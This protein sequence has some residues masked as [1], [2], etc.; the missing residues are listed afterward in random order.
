M[1]CLLDDDN[2]CCSSYDDV[3]DPVHPNVFNDVISESYNDIGDADDLM[4]EYEDMDNYDDIGDQNYEPLQW[5]GDDSLDNKGLKK[6]WKDQ[7]NHDTASD[8]YEEPDA[9]DDTYDNVI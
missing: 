4:Y 7:E 8:T 2:D 5:V 1:H 6:V 3:C 9:I